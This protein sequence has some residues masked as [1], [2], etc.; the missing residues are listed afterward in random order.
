M[1]RYLGGKLINIVFSL[2]ILATATFFLMKAVPGDP[3]TQEKAIPPEIKANI[4]AHYGLDKPLGEQYLIY[5]KKLFQFDLGLSMKS[6]NRTVTSII[7]DSFGTSAK[8]G[9]IAVVVS[10]IIGVYLGMMAALRHRGLVDNTAMFLAVIGISV[11]N[12]VIGAIIQYF[13]AVKVPIFHVAGLEGPL[14]YVLPT[15]ALCTLPIAFIAR[16]TRSTMLE[17]LTS[18]YIRTAKAKGLTPRAILWQHGLRNGIL[19]VVTYLGPMTA[20]II[21]GSVVVEQIFG[22]PGLGAYFVDSVM[23]RDYTL[24]MGITIFYAVIL[25]AARF[26]TDILYIF[27]DPRIKLSGGVVKS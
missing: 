10:V 23:N 16:L 8:V 22:L 13:L 20:N 2:L 26:V 18:D 27:V 24:I 5:M 11:P 1:V 9:A 4:M 6:Q 15:I 25:M 7:S 21:T 12:F 14:D 17:V 19:P 3:F